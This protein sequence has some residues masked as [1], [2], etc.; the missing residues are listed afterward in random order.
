[1]VFAPLANLLCGGFFS[2]QRSLT[3]RFFLYLVDNGLRE[4]PC[5]GFFPEFRFAEV[6]AD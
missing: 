6:D 4:T 3:K 1:L 5:D 2:K